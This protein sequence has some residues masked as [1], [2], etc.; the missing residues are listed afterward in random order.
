VADELSTL[1]IP[2]EWFLRSS[3]FRQ[4]EQ[5]RGPH[6][7]DFFAPNANNQRERFYLL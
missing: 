5:R 3:F 4:L 6:L 7:V 2:D 1:V